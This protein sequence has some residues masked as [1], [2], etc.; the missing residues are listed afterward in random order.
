M[1]NKGVNE[2]FGEKLFNFM[3]FSLGYL[4]ICHRTPHQTIVDLRFFILKLLFLVN[5]V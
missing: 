4:V 5:L 3:P 2:A 1:C